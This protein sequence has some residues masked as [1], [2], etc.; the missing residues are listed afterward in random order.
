M[1]ENLIQ[2]I[3]KTKCTLCG[4]C[5]T[6]CPAYRVL[7]NEAASARGRAICLKRGFPSKY[8]YLCMLCKACENACILKDIDLA[9]KIRKYRQELIAV[10]ITTEANKRMIN[11]IRQY[12]NPIGPIEKGKKI[13]LFCC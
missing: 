13:E 3:D 11:K 5:R 4:L 7:L 12:G 9:D 10:G 8:L 1:A 2:N 6:S